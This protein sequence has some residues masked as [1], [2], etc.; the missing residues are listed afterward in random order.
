MSDTREVFSRIYQYFDLFH[1]PYY[2]LM[3]MPHMSDEHGNIHMY[4]PHICQMGMEIYIRICRI[5][6]MSM[7][8]YICILCM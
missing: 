2:W 8:I 3:Y 4:I 1:L 5:F 6:Q 7:E